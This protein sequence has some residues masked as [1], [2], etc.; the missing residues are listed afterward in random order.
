MLGNKKQDANRWLITHTS[1]TSA[2]GVTLQL[3]LFIDLSE[4]QYVSNGVD[5]CLWYNYEAENISSAAQPTSESTKQIV[6]LTFISVSY[7]KLSLFQLGSDLFL[8]SQK[9]NQLENHM[10]CDTG[11]GA[12]FL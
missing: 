4:Y 9:E 2:S 1:I 10:L 5:D 7:F 12:A 8:Y 3:W 6:G 11:T